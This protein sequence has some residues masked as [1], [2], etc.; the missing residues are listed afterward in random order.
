V[1]TNPGVAQMLKQGIT[2]AVSKVENDPVSSA[3]YLET[4]NLSLPSE[5]TWVRDQI[6]IDI[7]GDTEQTSYKAFNQYLTILQTKELD[8][9]RTLT[10]HQYPHIVATNMTTTATNDSQY[11]IAAD[12]ERVTIGD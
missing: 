11:D 5:R 8:H 6:W 12:L 9:W 1:L 7:F 3:N 4:L 10:I 2:V